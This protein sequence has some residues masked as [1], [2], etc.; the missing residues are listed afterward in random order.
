M[1]EAA[2][3]TD[4]ELQMLEGLVDGAYALAMTFAE[5]A[6]A[7]RDTAAMLKLFDAY[8]RA[9][10]SVRLGIRLS[11]ILRAPAR[12]PAACSS[13]PADADAEPLEVEKD[14]SVTR[15]ERTERMEGLER[16]RDYESVSLPRFLA[17]LGVVATETE[18]LA[19]HLPPEVASQT[20]PALRDL[21]AQAKAAAAPPPPAPLL[22]RPTPAVGGVAVLARPPAAPK[23]VLLGSVSSPLRPIDPGGGPRPPPPRR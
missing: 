19:D 20:L 1:S 8:H 7:E 6:K 18:R 4:R 14:D 10:Q 15:P 11:M 5:A 16:D 17:S 3:R 23:S 9:S 2:T 21:L 22:A 13:A 12:A